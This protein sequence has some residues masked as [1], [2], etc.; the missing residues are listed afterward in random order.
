MKEYT[1]E[2]KVDVKTTTKKNMLE[3]SNSIRT[4]KLKSYLMNKKK[5]YRLGNFYL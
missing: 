2:G 3:F 1:F 5:N 4:Y